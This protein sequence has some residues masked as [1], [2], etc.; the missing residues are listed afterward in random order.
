[1]DE[2]L[3][4]EEIQDLLE[5]NV[6]HIGD[7]KTNEIKSIFLDADDLTKM[8]NRHK[9]LLAELSKYVTV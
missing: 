5:N 2:T 1:M 9:L 8:I 4:L 7:V 3:L 6:S